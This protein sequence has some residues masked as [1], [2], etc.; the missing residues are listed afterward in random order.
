MFVEQ[1]FIPHHNFEGQFYSRHCLLGSWPAMLQTE[2]CSCKEIKRRF[3]H[4]YSVYQSGLQNLSFI[5]L[6]SSSEK[7]DY[8]S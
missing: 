6:G 7:Q 5:S 8:E 3:A 4:Q 1:D 2:R